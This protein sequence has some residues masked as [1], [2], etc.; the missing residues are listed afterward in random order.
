MTAIIFYCNY[1]AIII[2]IRIPDI[3]QKLEGR[4][5]AVSFT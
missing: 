2:F 3:F 1:I 5:S 4:L